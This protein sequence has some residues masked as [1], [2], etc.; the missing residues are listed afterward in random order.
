MT[1][2]KGSGLQFGGTVYLNVVVIRSSNLTCRQLAT[3]NKNSDPVQK[4]FI[5][6]DLGGQCPQLKIVQTSG[7]VRNEYSS[8]SAG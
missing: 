4:L 7:I 8:T 6:D 1:P 2:N 3:M 5:N